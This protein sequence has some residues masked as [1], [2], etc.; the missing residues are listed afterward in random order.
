MVYP[1]PAKTAEMVGFKKAILQ[2]KEDRYSHKAKMRMPAYA[3]KRLAENIPDSALNSF[4]SDSILV[5]IPKSGLHQKGAHWPAL[6]IC[7]E[8]V[9]A[10]VAHQFDCA[11]ERVSPVRKSAGSANRP[12][13]AEHFES[14]QVLLTPNTGSIVLVDDIITRGSTGVGSAWRILEA[15]PSTDVKIFA[16]ARTL[17]PDDINGILDPVVGNVQFYG[18]NRLHREP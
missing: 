5:P 16:I 8:L 13:P 10:G 3:A 11:L 12:S 7:Q 17:N 4:F 1:S 18:D 6:C 14:L 2:I 15:M 9:N